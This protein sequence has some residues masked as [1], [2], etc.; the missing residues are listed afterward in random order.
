ML[1]RGLEAASHATTVDSKDI[2]HQAVQLL[3]AALGSSAT[4]SLHVYSFTK[5]AGESRHLTH[6]APALISYSS[7]SCT[8]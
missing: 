4:I 7:F 6:S 8:V 3:D 1:P 2:C 5:A